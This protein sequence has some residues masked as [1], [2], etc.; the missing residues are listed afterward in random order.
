MLDFTIESPNVEAWR[1]KFQ[2]VMLDR[3]ARLGPEPSGAL[4]NFH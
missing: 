1:Q 4:A 2:F 3:P